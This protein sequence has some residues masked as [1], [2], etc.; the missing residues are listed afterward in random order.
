MKQAHYLK[1]LLLFALFISSCAKQRPNNNAGGTGSSLAVESAAVKNL[2]DGLQVTLTGNGE[3]AYNVY[4]LDDAR[5][6]VIDLPDTRIDLDDKSLSVRSDSI[7]SVSFAEFSDTISTLGR[8]SVLFKS[9]P[10]LPQIKAEGNKLIMRF[11]ASEELVATPEGDRPVP[12]NQRG[13]ESEAEETQDEEETPER[14]FLEKITCRSIGGKTEVALSGNGRFS[15]Y[16]EKFSQKDQKLLL[17]FEDLQFGATKTPACPPGSYVTAL[18]LDA[19]NRQ[20]VLTTKD[21]T[22]LGYAVTSTKDGLLVQF[23]DPSTAKGEITAIEFEQLPST[24]RFAIVVTSPMA[25]EEFREGELSQGLRL[26]N[27][28]IPY[29]LRR[30]FDTREFRSSIVHMVPYDKPK[31]IVTLRLT[32]KN[33]AAM[34]TRWDG[35]RLIWDIAVNPLDKVGPAKKQAPIS[36]AQGE[37]MELDDETPG[38]EAAPMELGESPEDLQDSEMREEIGLAPEDMED[39]DDSDLTFTDP[40]DLGKAPKLAG[41]PKESFSE[42]RG[43]FQTIPQRIIDEGGLDVSLLGKTPENKYTGRKI[44]INFENADIRYV[45]KLLADIKKVNFVFDDSVQGTITLKMAQVPWD[46]VLDILL[47]SKQLDKQELGNSII[48]IAPKATLRLESEQ[49]LVTQKV[50]EQVRPKKTLVKPINFAKAVDMALKI[51]NMAQGKGQVE[52]DE[53][54]NTLIISATEDQIEY[55]NKIVELL[56]TQTP[57]VSIEARIVQANTSFARKFGVTWSGGMSFSSGSGNPTGLIF[58]NDISVAGDPN[59]AVPNTFFGF[60]PGNTSTA[61]NLNLGSINGILDI[62]LR[63]RMMESWGYGK[64][65]SSPKVTVLD[66]QTARIESG[67]QVPFSSA[68]ANTG[69]NIQFQS[70][71]TS[72]NVTPHVTAD[73]SISMLITATKNAPNFA[74]AIN[75][76]PTIETNSATSTILVKSGNTTVLGG[77]YETAN[78]ES[79][80]GVPFLGRL[81][82]IGALFRK[83]SI[84]DTRKELLFFITPRIVKDTRRAVRD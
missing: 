42:A 11:T 78:S 66:N 6:V 69:T 77:T 2:A 57:Q 14:L 3:L 74:L 82:F 53:R 67:F 29:Y 71:N 39:I 56:D 50:E 9:A 43:E 7:A 19:R 36:L 16:K 24:S 70:A 81:P 48:R 1:V 80:E 32:M 33:S 55:I 79:N 76:N 46:Q 4:K 40:G 47:Q 58:P 35:N 49:L 62:G 15:G 12:R 60:D 65:I 83:T 8:M 34:K 17:D 44:S 25:Y 5:M 18:Q 20:L 54:T 27:A 72:I 38:G 41:G 10:L 61:F 13:Q 75:G 73:G 28:S 23:F 63:L 21:V 30:I 84:S 51:K 31:G 22:S 59:N 64:I 52:V 37:L 68:A 26:K 45:L